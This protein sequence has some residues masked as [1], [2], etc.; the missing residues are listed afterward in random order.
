MANAKCMA[1][2]LKEFTAGRGSCNNGEIL[3]HTDHFRD[4]NIFTVVCDRGC[5]ISN[6]AWIVSAF[7]R[8]RKFVFDAEEGHWNKTVYF[9][10]SPYVYYLS[11]TI[12]ILLLLYFDF[13]FFFLISFKYLSFVQWSF[14]PLFLLF[15]FLFLFLS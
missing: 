3:K 15:F 10:S 8:N 13:F 4:G 7:G 12:T 6:A 1:L 14:V 2:G 11:Y 5:R 9:T